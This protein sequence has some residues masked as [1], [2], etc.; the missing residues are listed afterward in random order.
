MLWM[1]CEQCP[2]FREFFASVLQGQRLQI[3]EYADEVVPG[4]ELQAYHDKELWV[5][6]WSFLDFGPAALANEDAWFTGLTL[7]S[8]IAKNKIAGGIG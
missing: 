3:V 7:R 4:R 5:L 8:S 2:E 6:Y 1:W